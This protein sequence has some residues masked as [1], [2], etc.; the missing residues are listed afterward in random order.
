MEKKVWQRP[1]LTVLV[2]CRPEE[3]VLSFCKTMT[4]SDGGEVSEEGGTSDSCH[5]P[6]DGCPPCNYEGDGGS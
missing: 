4:G 6:G 3:A 2:K 1:E 5:N